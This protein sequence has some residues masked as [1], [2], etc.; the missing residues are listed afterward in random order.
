MRTHEDY[1]ITSVKRKSD[2]KTFT[3]GGEVFAPY[4]AK[5]KALR[6]HPVSNGVYKLVGDVMFTDGTFK[7][8]LDV[9]TFK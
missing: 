4:Q 2:G 1:E 6:L 9:E 5:L 3:V 7:Q 8:S